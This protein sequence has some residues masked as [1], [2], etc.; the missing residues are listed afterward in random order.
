M[1]INGDQP[2]AYFKTMEECLLLIS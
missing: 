2:E 1:Q